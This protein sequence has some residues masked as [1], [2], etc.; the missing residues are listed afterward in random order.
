VQKRVLVQV[1]HPQNEDEEK[2]GNAMTKLNSHLLAA[3]LLVAMGLLLWIP[4]RME[5]I[6]AKSAVEVTSLELI[7]RFGVGGLFVMSGTAVWLN[8]LFKNN[9]TKKVTRK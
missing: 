4:A 5:I 9:Q 7:F 2:G 1:R 8:W 6:S 3:F